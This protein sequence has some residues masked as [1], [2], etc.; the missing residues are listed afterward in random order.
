MVYFTVIWSL[1]T[2]SQIVAWILLSLV[3][4]IRKDDN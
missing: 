2:I 3:S 4:L 1:V